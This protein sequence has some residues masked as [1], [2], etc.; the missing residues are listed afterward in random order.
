MHNISQVGLNIP[1]H[2]VR[3]IMTAASKIEGAIHL[4]IGEPNVTTPIHIREAAKA[5]MDAGMTHY[6]A[7]AGFDSLRVYLASRKCMI[8]QLKM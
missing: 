2:G 4:E 5:A 6:T 3:E 8:W 1:R 7:N